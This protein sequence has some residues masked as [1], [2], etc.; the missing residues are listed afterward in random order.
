MRRM[1]IGDLWCHRD[2]WTY[3][4]GGPGIIFSRGFWDHFDW[5]EWEATPPKFIS[6]VDD[7]SLGGYLK[8]KNVKLVHHMGISQWEPFYGDGKEI[9]IVRI[10]AYS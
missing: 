7:V 8:N 6:T 9:D 3:P 4:S 5:E 10:M 1:V 2:N